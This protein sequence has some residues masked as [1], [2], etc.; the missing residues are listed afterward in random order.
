MVVRRLADEDQRSDF[1]PI[2]ASFE[3]FFGRTRCHVRRCLPG[4]GEVA[5]LD[6]TLGLNVLD[7]PIRI[8]P[9]QV[10]ACFGPAPEPIGDRLYP[11]IE[12][13]S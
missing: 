5:S 6:A 8:V 2:H 7:P 9:Q 12:P 1:A 13:R 3:Q 4:G 10:D 11:N